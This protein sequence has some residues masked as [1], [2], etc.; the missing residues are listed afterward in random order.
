MSLMVVQI[1][2][3]SSSLDQWALAGKVALLLGIGG[4][5]VGLFVWRALLRATAVVALDL[6]K[7][8]WQARV[9]EHLK[10]REAASAL[11]FEQVDRELDLIRSF[12]GEVNR[13]LSEHDDKLEFTE[14][15]IHEQGKALMNQFTDAINRQTVSIETIARNTT[16]ALGE[17]KTAVKDLT[18]DTN[19]TAKQVSEMSGVLRASGAWTG[20]N[21]RIESRDD[22][23]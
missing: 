19:Q 22:T 12:G 4:S 21:R 18:K 5:V 6:C 1:A 9:D 10:E 23:R 17:I 16:E 8:D 13:R 3:P 15:S 7:T 14:A 2:P 11:A 20:V